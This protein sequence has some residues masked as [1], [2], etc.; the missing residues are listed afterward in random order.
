MNY[1]FTIYYREREENSNADGLSRQAWSDE[2][3]A[4]ISPTATDFVCI[5]IIFLTASTTGADLA[6]GRCLN[7][8]KREKAVERSKNDY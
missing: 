4:L 6:G 3:S 8:S 2:T 1:D 5:P 7:T